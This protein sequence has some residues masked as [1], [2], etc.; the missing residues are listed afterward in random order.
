M[1]CAVLA[2]PL[3]AK[4]WQ[5]HRSVEMLAYDQ[6]RHSVSIT[7][8][9]LANNLRKD[10]LFRMLHR[11]SVACNRIPAWP[12][13]MHQAQRGQSDHNILE[14]LYGGMFIEKDRKLVWRNDITIWDGLIAMDEKEIIPAN[15]SVGL[16]PDYQSRSEKHMPFSSW[17]IRVKQP[18]W[19]LF[20]FDLYFD[21]DT[22]DALLP[23]QKIFTVDGP[24]RLLARIQFEDLDCLT[25]S[26]YQLWSD[27]LKNFVDSDTRLDS[28]SYDIILLGPPYAAHVVR[29]RDYSTD[30]VYLSPRQPLVPG[31]ARY[32]TTDCAF[33]LPLSYRSMETEDSE[34]QSTALSATR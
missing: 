18:G 15:D 28:S 30:G 7:L 17:T 32:I 2:A 24:E 20:A 1:H 14:D 13:P 10:N 4:T 23:K 3:G 8:L 26:D 9:L 12:F 25:N 27:R 5:I 11:G 33:C 6:K 22:Y 31:A 29:A 19:Y 34:L 16:H 21:G